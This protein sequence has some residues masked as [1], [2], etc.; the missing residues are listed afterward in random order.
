MTPYPRF[1]LS[2]FMEIGQTVAAHLNIV[3]KSVTRIRYE[4]VFQSSKCQILGGSIGKNL[5][6]LRN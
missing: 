5:V 2:V 3:K 6:N 4:G 1:E